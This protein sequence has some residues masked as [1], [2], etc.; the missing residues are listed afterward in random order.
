MGLDILSEGTAV[1]FRSVYS[2]RDHNELSE[3]TFPP[4]LE[5]QSFYTYRMIAYDGGFWI[6]RDVLH[7]RRARTSLVYASSVS[8]YR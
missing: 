6:V 1:F 4:T 7:I 5:Q 3:R 2:P 8:C